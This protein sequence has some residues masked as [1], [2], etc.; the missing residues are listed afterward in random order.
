MI[1][2]AVFDKLPNFIGRTFQYFIDNG[3]NFAPK[4]RLLWVM[5]ILPVGKGSS[6]RILPYCHILR[7]KRRDFRDLGKE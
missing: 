2:A 7:A 4:Q 3:K 1:S 6:L 5:R